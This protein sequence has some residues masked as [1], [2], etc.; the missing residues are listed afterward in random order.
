MSR[1][2]LVV[3]LAIAR[4]SHAQVPAKVDS[5]PVHYF[6]VNFKDVKWEK[7]FPEFGSDSP[8]ISILRVDP[9][10]KATQLLIR[11]PAALHVPKHW[12]SANE[13]HT[14]ISGTFTV[15]CEGKREAL[16]PGSFNYVPAKMQHEAW[17][18]PGMLLF[19]TVDSA[20]D[21]NWVT[22]PPTKADFGVAAP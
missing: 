11:T 12:H 7:M 16:A 8:Q 15:E 10:T 1:V 6:S 22:G 4:I 5:E 9:K 17:T 3:L 20:W 2:A 19:I 21:I 14:I 18:T 13:T